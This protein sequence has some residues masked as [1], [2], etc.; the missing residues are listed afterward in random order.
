MHS[1]S[2]AVLAVFFACA[3]GYSLAIDKSKAIGPCGPNEWCPPDAYCVEQECYPSDTPKL[4]APA[5]RRLGGRR[6]DGAIG[7][8]VNGKCP[9]GFKCVNERCVRDGAKVNKGAIG[10]CINNLCPNSFTCN[11]DDY[12]CYP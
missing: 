3:I 10:P 7:P 4:Y 8:C 5:A 9:N 2:V 12:Q 6:S 1:P 11:M